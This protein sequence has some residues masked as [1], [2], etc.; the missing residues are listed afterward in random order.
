MINVFFFLLK[1]YINLKKYKYHFVLVQ[2]PMIIID[3]DAPFILNNFI[4]YK[5][6]LL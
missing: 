6:D 4:I 5:N 3:L 1:K 2:S